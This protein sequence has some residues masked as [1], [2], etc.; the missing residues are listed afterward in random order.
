MLLFF[1][2]LVAF[3]ILSFSA[4]PV[5]YAKKLPTV[6]LHIYLPKNEDG[7]GG[8]SK[9]GEDKGNNKAA[10][11]LEPTTVGSDYF[12]LPEEMKPKPGDNTDEGAEAEASP[13]VIIQEPKKSKPSLQL[14]PGMC[15]GVC[16]MT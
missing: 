8:I 12:D 7:Y 15:D 9:Y 3:E 5:P 1:L 10:D 13:T 16:E 6:N 11:A 14:D 4:E 2:L